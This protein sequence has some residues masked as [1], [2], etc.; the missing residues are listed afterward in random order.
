MT[1][2]ILHIG[3]LALQGAFFEHIKLL[4]QAVAQL[5]SVSEEAWNIVILEVRTAN[6]LQCCEALIIPG[7]E[8]TTVSL[9]AE[10]SNLL[11]PLRHFVKVLRKPTWGTC[12]GLI[13]LAESANRV[14]KGGQELIGGLDVR[15]NRNYFGRQTE[16]FEADLNLAFLPKEISSDQEPFRGIFIRAPIVEKILPPASGEQKEEAV[17]DETVIAPA[18]DII[19]GQGS[20]P[21]EVMATLPGRSKRLTEKLETADL[22]EETGDI[23]AVRQRNVFGTSFHPELTSDVRIH[24]W[25]LRE[26]LNAYL[27]RMSSDKPKEC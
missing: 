20:S 19:H 8:S 5:R 3:V 21:V 23:I 17:R 12:A 1:P 7:G 9:V 10:R 27:R 22:D 11:E 13:L 14:K 16:S 2:V 24:I 4:R 18:K 25:W 6:D 15:V 26:V